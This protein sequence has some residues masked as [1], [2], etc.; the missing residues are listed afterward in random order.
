MPAIL[1]GARAVPAA[2]GALTSLKAVYL[3]MTHLLRC[4]QC[5]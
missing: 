5:V 1:A 4:Y 2:R 3:N